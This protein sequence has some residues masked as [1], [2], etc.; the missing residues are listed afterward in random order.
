MEVRVNYKVAPQISEP[1]GHKDISRKNFFVE[2]GFNIFIGDDN[3]FEL[4]WGF[5]CSQ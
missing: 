3:R 1:E 4:D 2:Y 5:V